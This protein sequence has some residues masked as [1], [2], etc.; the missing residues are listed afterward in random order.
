MLSPLTTYQVLPTH[1]IAGKVREHL[2]MLLEYDIDLDYLI[3]LLSDAVET[4]LELGPG[5]METN[6]REDFGVFVEC[7]F[8]DSV[9][10]N[11]RL[12]G[13]LD[14]LSSVVEVVIDALEILYL[15]LCPCFTSII[16]PSD[17]T[18]CV[19]FNFIRWLGDDIL[20]ASTY[21]RMTV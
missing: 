10:F 11:E 8:H 16:D 17:E 18:T 19:S 3:S 14:R 9:E 2:A 5:R 4:A 15:T 12:G 7:D 6:F 21:H 20:I 1:D 13:D